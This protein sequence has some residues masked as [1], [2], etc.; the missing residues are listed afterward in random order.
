MEMLIKNKEFTTIKKIDFANKTYSIREQTE[1]EEKT[2]RKNW[3]VIEV[4]KTQY[5]KITDWLFNYGFKKV[6]WQ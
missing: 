1:K 3:A 4:S 6:D 5:Y 2:N